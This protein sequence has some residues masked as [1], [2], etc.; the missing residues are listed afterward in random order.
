[1]G[2]FWNTS[3]HTR[4]TI[5]PKLP[6][7]TPYPQITNPHPMRAQYMY[8]Y[9]IL[10]WMHIQLPNFNWSIL[11]YNV[12]FPKINLRLNKA[13]LLTRLFAVR[14]QNWFSI[15]GHTDVNRQCKWDNFCD[16]LFALQ[17]AKVIRSFW[18]RFD[19]KNKEHGS[20]FAPFRVDP[21]LKWSQN[22]FTGVAVRKIVSL[23]P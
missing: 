19:F 17:H 8:M 12:Q 9:W 7:P 20:N 1:M 15:F 4:T 21:F 18:K 13:L 10:Y 11:T 23:P 16:F 22:H 5:T 3:S 14:T 6:I 2:W